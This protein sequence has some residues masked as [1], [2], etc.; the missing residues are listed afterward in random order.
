MLLKDKI[1]FLR[2]DD[3]KT[4]ENDEHYSAVT[5]LTNSVDYNTLGDKMYNSIDNTPDY[6]TNMAFIIYRKTPNIESIDSVLQAIKAFVSETP[7][8]NSC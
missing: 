6:L 1:G 5:K 7:E 2:T 8:K 4:I 3:R